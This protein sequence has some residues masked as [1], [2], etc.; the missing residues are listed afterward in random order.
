MPTRVS[1][2]LS[3]KNESLHIYTWGLNMPKRRSGQRNVHH[4]RWNFRSY[5]VSKNYILI[6]YNY[7]IVLN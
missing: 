2:R 7:Y 6:V 4:S 3:S 1:T 5:Q